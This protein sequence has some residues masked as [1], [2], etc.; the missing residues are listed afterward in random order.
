M[1]FKSA[2]TLFFCIVWILATNY[3]ST[4]LNSLGALMTYKSGLL[5][6]QE[7]HNVPLEMSIDRDLTI[8]IDSFGIPYIYSNDNNNL[9]FGLGY[10]HAKDRY[11]QMELMCK[12]VKG[13]LAG[14]F[15]AR[16]IPSDEFWKPFEFDRKAIEILEEYQTSA[17][18]LYQYL[19]NYS[20]GVN[21]YLEK[22]KVNNPLY[23][24]FNAQPQAWKPEY[25][26]FVTWYMSKNLTYY[27]LHTERQ[28]LIDKLPSEMLDILYPISPDALKTILPSGVQAR[29]ETTEAQPTEKVG[30]TNIT[31]TIHY[32]D[33]G[34]NNWAVNSQKTKN[35]IPLMANDPHLF[36]TLPGAFYEA[37]LIGNTIKAYGYT[38]PGVPLIISGHNTTISWG[39]TN[40]EWDLTDR[41]LLQTKNDSLYLY[42]G[43]WIPF[44]EKQYSIK[45]RGKGK[46][47]FNIK[48]TIHGLVK[49]EDSIYYAQKWYP[50]GKNYSTKALFNVMQSN[51]YNEFK[52][53]LKT[54]DYPPQNFIYADVND[55]IGIVCA[56][57]LPKRPQGFQGGLLDGTSIPLKEEFIITQ[58]E[59][60]NPEQ[61]YLFS[62]NQLPV[63]NE[64]Y[65]GAHWHKDD[66]RVTRID[67]LLKSKNDWNVQDFKSMQSDE[68]DISFFHLKEVFQDQ[69]INE[70]YTYINELLSSWNGNMREDSREAFIYETLRKCVEKEAKRFANE[71]LGVQQ[72]PS[73]KSFLN[74]LSDETS[75]NKGYKS[76]NKIVK[77]I[78]KT[79]DSILDI[80]NQLRDK[81]YNQMSQ[82][83][84]YN[85][86]FLPG[87]GHKIRN[88]GGN[89]NT[90]NMNAS[91]HPIFRSIYEMEK[92]NIKGYTIMAGGQSGKINSKNYID[93]IDDWKN[94]NYKKTQF[95]ENSEELK[96]ITATLFFK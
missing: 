49:K 51:S 22:N 69:I 61:N 71:E 65:F 37:S 95:T 58:W 5:E 57:K 74:Y 35:G 84:L 67:S 10:M 41:Y 34:S 63:Q 72:V 8:K 14:M 86:S 43:N 70:K 93:Q 91:A 78:L 54:Y 39:I 21:T 31:P 16:A 29:A 89:K 33:I 82:I 90:I 53:A 6:I 55:T 3:K 94:G 9:A 32:T 75:Y 81:K 15:G 7:A 48:S 1:K 87:F 12:M 76:K 40:G 38:I 36:V 77:T 23:T 46:E 28:E 79:T 42:Q 80:E 13:E 20:Q 30:L 68:V 4:P 50:S 2:I 27:D 62:A 18:D 52:S 88:A 25:C 73:M 24:L 83:N 47:E 96:N 59:T 44:Q 26:L 60:S 17:P 56:G 45:V 11:F 19:L 92:D 85:I 64:Q 66:Y